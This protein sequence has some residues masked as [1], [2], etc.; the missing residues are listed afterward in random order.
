MWLQLDK[1]VADNA[2]IL[3]VKPYFRGRIKFVM[4]SFIVKSSQAVFIL[5][6]LKSTRFSHKARYD[7]YQKS[8]V[9]DYISYL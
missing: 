8:L 4:Q 7:D 3:S 1:P 5:I 9:E 6:C 2:R